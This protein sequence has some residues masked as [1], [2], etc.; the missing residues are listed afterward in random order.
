[1]Q[2][3]FGSQTY[4]LAKYHIQPSTLDVRCSMLSPVQFPFW[5][6]WPFSGQGLGSHETAT[7]HF[8]PVPLSMGLKKE[9]LHRIKAV[10]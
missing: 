10:K 9:I 8:A 3:A 1:M 5:S 2:L 4:R 7:S 6:V